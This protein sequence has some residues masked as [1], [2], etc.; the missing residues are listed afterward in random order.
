MSGVKFNPPWKGM[1]IEFEDSDPNTDPDADMSSEWRKAKHEYER[2]IARQVEAGKESE[3]CEEI[4]RYLQSI[5][6]FESYSIEELKEQIVKSPTWQAWVSKFN[7]PEKRNQQ[8]RKLSAEYAK[9][10]MSPEKVKEI[11]LKQSKPSGG[12]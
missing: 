10:F 11:V 2:E 6:G 7:T 8:F 3:W 4:A 9:S 1:P 12:A 5:P